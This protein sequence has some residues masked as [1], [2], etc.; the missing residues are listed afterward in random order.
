M[1]TPELPST[2]PPISGGAS[3]AR[4]HLLGAHARVEEAAATARRTLT[5]AWES[6]AADRFRDDVEDLV[7]AVRG[8]LAAVEA[9]VGAVP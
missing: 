2:E 6:P 7:A 5:V 1:T 4:D 8:D 9:A 3:A